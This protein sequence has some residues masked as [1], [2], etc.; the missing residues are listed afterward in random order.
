[1]IDKQ[2]FGNGDVPTKSSNVPVLRKHMPELDVLRG[3]A[4]LAVVLYHGL[5]WSGAVAIGPISKLVIQASVSGWLGVNLF[6]VL[7]GFLITGILLDTKGQQS[8]YR[9]FY[10]RRVVRILPAYFATIAILVLLHRFTFGSTVVALLFLANYDAIY[11]LANGYWPFWSLS[12]EEQFYLLWPAL[13]A[14]VRLQALTFISFGICLFEPL[15]RYLSASGRLPL[16]EVHL[17]TYLIADNLAMGALAAIF[18]RSRHATLRNA[19]KLGLA[20]IAA[21]VACLFIGLPFGILH[22]TNVFGAALQ[23]VPWNFIFTGT[24]LFLLGLRS[25]LFSGIYT[26]PLRFLGYISYGLYLCHLLIFEAY[27]TMVQHISRSFLRLTLQGS[28]TR[29]FLAGTIAVLVAWLSRR[30]FEA[31]FLRLKIGSHTPKTSDA[32]HPIPEYKT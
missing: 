28:F 5:Y 3:V 7:S 15:L 6:F 17:S 10:L 21:G 18:V 8:Y 29:L 31:P 25:P 12:V 27:D 19:V 11:P 13:V 9:R 20:I 2:A 23:T 32:S 16:G 22:R 24:L 1:M 30:F 26:A 14:N 4:I